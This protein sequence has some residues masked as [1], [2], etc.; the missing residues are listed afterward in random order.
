MTDPHDEWKDLTDLVRH[1]PLEEWHEEDQ[2]DP[3]P[4]GWWIA[5]GMFVGIAALVC[6]TLK[7]L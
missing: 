1:E 4:P 6:L 7:L 2:R 3:L 5:P